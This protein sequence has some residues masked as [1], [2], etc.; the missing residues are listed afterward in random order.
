MSSRRFSVCFISP[1]QAFYFIVTTPEILKTQPQIMLT[2]SQDVGKNLE[3]LVS[4]QVK[5]KKT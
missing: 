1:K 5:A 3:P 4:F 2:L